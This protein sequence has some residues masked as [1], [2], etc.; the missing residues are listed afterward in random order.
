MADEHG[1][2]Y[3]SDG[4]R[5]LTPQEIRDRCFNPTRLGRRGLDPEEVHQFLKLVEADLGLLHQ[6]LA[7]AREEAERLKDALRDWQ[8]QHSGCYQRAR[9][10][11]HQ[12]YRR[13]GTTSSNPARP[14]APP[15]PRERREHP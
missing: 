10:D 13:S 14:P 3:R 11:G 12:Q 6:E 2:V 15:H 4:R 8:S 5:L 7:A 9:Q 1:T